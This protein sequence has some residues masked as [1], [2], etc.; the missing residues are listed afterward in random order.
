MVA[1]EPDVSVRAGAGAELECVAHGHP[2]PSILWR[3]E[4]H[5]FNLYNELFQIHNKVH[6]N[7]ISETNQYR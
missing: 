1:R 7:G 4:K 5:E 2:A 6:N 3:K